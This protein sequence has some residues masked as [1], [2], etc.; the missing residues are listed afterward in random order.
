MSIC[1]ILIGCWA[2]IPIASIRNE[3]RIIYSRGLVSEQDEKA[4]G[5]C[6]FE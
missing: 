6:M 4:S 2:R 3:A 5:D 1:I